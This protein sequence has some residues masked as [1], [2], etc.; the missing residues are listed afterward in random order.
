[1]SNTG[2]TNPGKGKKHSP[3]ISLR[4]IWLIIIVYLLYL[5]FFPQNNKYQISYDEFR[6]SLV[7][8][9]VES[10]VISE[11]TIT[12]L[13]KEVGEDT[14]QVDTSKSNDRN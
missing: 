14:V 10:V 2:K 4:W 1:M 8:D 11:T 6:D 13:Y 9:R 12:G 3:W 5:L 7:L